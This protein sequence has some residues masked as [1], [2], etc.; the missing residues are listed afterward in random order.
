MKTVLDL[1]YRLQRKLW[2]L[3]R[4]RTRGVK[5]MLFNE[6]GQVLLIRN[7]YGRT[8]LWLLPG[9]GVRPFERPDAAA[10]RE[11]REELGLEAER[12]T[13]LSTH[14]SPAEGKRDTIHLYKASAAGEPKIDDIE[15][16]EARFFPVGE[17][18]AATSPAT[19]RRLDEYRGLRKVS[20]IW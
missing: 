11:V 2:K 17:L 9:G 20:E 6:A 7:S 10:R 19:R 18:P 14:F 8:D 12:L 16:A 1:L 3:L 5:V 13:F 15:V 4:P